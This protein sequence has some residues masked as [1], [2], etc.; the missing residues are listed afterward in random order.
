M[1]TVIG[2]LSIATLDIIGTVIGGI[3]LAAL[4]VLCTIMLINPIIKAIKSIK[5]YLNNNKNKKYKKADE[6][7]TNASELE[8]TNSEEALKS[9]KKALWI[10][11]TLGETRWE[12]LILHQI[13][14]IYYSQGKY[15]RALFHLYM[16]AF[17]R[18][19]LKD[20]SGKA[21]TY[22][23]INNVYYSKRKNKDLGKF[24]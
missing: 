21:V 13:G 11:F 20:A 1:K 14:V 2:L 6:L 10:D 8:T 23:I 24:I 7:S 9:Y 22:K 15:V 12:G 17:I 18:K 16:A 19:A 4:M 5:K 3:F